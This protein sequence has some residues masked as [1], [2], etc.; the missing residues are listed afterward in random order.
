M[1]TD[2]EEL[3]VEQMHKQAAGAAWRPE[4]LHGALRRHR[5]GRSR[6]RILY[7]A[8]AVGAAAAVAV[9]VAVAAPGRSAPA[10]IHPKLQ[11]IAYV[12]TRTRK[13]VSA[14]ARDVLEI[15]S[16]AGN[17]WSYTTWIDQATGR[18]RLDLR[19]PSTASEPNEDF[20]GGKYRPLMTVDYQNRSWWSIR[21]PQQGGSGARLRVSVMPAL[22]VA[23]STSWGG[24]GAG[25]PTPAHLSK[26]L[27]DGAFRL[28]G[29]E[30]VAGQRLLHLRGIVRFGLKLG[31]FGLDHTVDLWVSPG[32][33]LP[34]RSSAYEGPSAPPLT[35]EFSWLQPTAANLAVLAPRIPA[36]FKHQAPR[37]P[38][39]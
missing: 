29:S 5:T 24:W 33:Y 39:G 34:V 19:G 12:L 31:T 32:S 26:D 7:P 8:L 3:L 15:R 17:G 14:D 18:Y 25:L 13:A 37:C 23:I 4:L 35:S 38:C 9:S 6:R 11:T 30:T 1:N 27:A 22:I 2:V 10:K 16:S 20:Y 36:G 28:L 21:P